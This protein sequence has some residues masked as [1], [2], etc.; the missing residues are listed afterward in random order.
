MHLGY[1]ERTDVAT[2]GTRFFN[3]KGMN[4]TQRTEIFEETKEIQAKLD[5]LHNFV[6]EQRRGGSN[7][8]STIARAN[9]IRFRGHFNRA[10]IQ[11]ALD[12]RVAKNSKAAED[13]EKELAAV[14][15]DKDVLEAIDGEA[16]GFFTCDL[17]QMNVVEFLLDEDGEASDM[18]G[19]GLAV[20]RP[21]FVIDDPTQLHIDM[22]SST[23]V[24]QSAIQV[25]FI[26]F[27]YSLIYLSMPSFV[28]CHQISD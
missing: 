26:Y 5:L 19:F 24:V 9:D 6:A 12:Q 2:M 22:I 14:V 21:E 15:F 11:R 10:R 1:F 25:L 20:K 13:M 18:L 8:M 28:G 3:R 16:R 4:K 23:V 7:S 17:S 27:Y